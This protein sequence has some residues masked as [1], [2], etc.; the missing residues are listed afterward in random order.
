MFAILNGIHMLNGTNF[1]TL[2]N[3]ITLVLGCM[4]LEY[5]L[6][7]PWASLVEDQ[8]SINDKKVFER[9]E[10]SNHIGLMIMKNIILKAFFFTL[11]LRIRILSNYSTACKNASL[12]V[13]RRIKTIATLKKLVSIRYKSDRNIWEYILDTCHLTRKL[14][15]LKIE[16]PQ[17]V[18]VHMML[19]SLPPQ[20]NQFEVNYNFQKEKSQQMTQFSNSSISQP[21]DTY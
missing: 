16:L 13:I 18:L 4:D 20:F 17:D 7:E 6:R 1:K 14:K 9:W 15:G 2:K 3:K 21:D 5:V 8:S 11:G 19:I 10:W 12:R